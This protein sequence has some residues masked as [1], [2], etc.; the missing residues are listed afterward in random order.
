MISHKFRCKYDSVGFTFK[1]GDSI[2]VA[3][4]VKYVS[5]KN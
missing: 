5:D 3:K 4:V 2:V 1:S